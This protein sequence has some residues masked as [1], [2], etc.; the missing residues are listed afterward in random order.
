MRTDVKNEMSAMRTDLKNEMSAMRT[1]LKN[2]L[3]FLRVDVA[4]LKE[5]II[6]LKVD[7]ARVI[8]RQQPCT[9]NEPTQD[10]VRKGLRRPR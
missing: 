7:M 1:D 9:T 3:A 10:H 4:A 5:D 8:G 2:D 6:D